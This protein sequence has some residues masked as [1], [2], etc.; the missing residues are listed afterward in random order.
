MHNNSAHIRFLNMCIPMKIIKNRH[1]DS[2]FFY[3]HVSGMNCLIP[4]A[5]SPIS[6]DFCWNWFIMNYLYLK[7]IIP[8]DLENISNLSHL[9]L[10]KH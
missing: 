8:T 9:A 10:Q 3:W 2:F 4:N 1:I 5:S 7:Q 6:V